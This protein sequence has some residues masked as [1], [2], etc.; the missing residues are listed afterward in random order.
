MQEFVDNRT[1]VGP[2]ENYDYP[3]TGNGPV[4][5]CDRFTFVLYVFV[6]GGLCV[7]GLVGNTLS[8]LVLRSER[9]GHVATFLLQTMAVADNVFLTTTALSQ[10]TMALTMYTETSMHA[11]AAASPSTD[12]DQRPLNDL[13]TITAY[14]QVRRPS[15]I[16]PSIFILH[17]R[18]QF[19]SANEKALGQDSETLYLLYYCIFTCSISHCLAAF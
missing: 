17:K 12:I 13:Y 6:L 4:E 7:F 19:I 3:E 11:A 16:H 9:R 18:K 5:N 10:M 8:F 15:S 1:Y 14:V 2:E